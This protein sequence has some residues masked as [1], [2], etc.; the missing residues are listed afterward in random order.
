MTTELKKYEELLKK[1]EQLKK[2]KPKAIKTNKKSYLKAP[3]TK[4][5][6][7]STEKLIRQLQKESGAL[8]TGENLYKR[9]GY[10]KD[11][12]LEQKEKGINWLYSE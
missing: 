7:Y 6:S 2:Q 5:P 8:V 4:L 11:K 10:F 9:T 1:I 3:K 12:W